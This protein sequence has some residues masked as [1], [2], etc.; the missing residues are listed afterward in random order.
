MIEHTVGW[1]PHQVEVQT[2][3][4]STY[5]GGMKTLNNSG[6]ETLEWL[7]RKA[8]LPCQFVQYSRLSIAYK[9]M[10]TITSL[11][12][13]LKCKTDQGVLAY[14]ALQQVDTIFSEALVAT[15]RNMHGYP[16]NCCTVMPAH[17]EAGVQLLNTTPHK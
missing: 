8:S 5:L 10:V 14:T 12:T 3:G 17:V 4:R 11:V 6:K 1:L 7:L 15:T 2:T 13:S 16:K 9:V